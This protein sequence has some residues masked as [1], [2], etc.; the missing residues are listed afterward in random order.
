M[1]FRSVGK[2]NTNNGHRYTEIDRPPRIVDVLRHGATVAHFHRYWILV[3]ARDA[4]KSPPYSGSFHA[5]TMKVGRLRATLTF[6]RAYTASVT[7]TVTLSG[8]H[9]PRPE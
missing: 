7:A 5:L 4:G 8:G 2:E 9:Q 6:R 3:A 1:S